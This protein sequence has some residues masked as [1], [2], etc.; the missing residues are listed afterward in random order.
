MRIITYHCMSLPYR[1][2]GLM[3]TCYYLLLPVILYCYRYV[4]GMQYLALFNVILQYHVIVYIADSCYY[5]C[6]LSLLIIT[7]CGQPVATL[8]CTHTHAH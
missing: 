5:Y 6:Y 3:I 7:Y 1:L 4:L 2:L 8:R